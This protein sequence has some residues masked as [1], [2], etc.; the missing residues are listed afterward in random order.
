M[1]FERLLT[2]PGLVCKGPLA[3]QKKTADLRTLKTFLKALGEQ[4]SDDFLGKEYCLGANKAA[5]LLA[6]DS[7]SVGT[8]ATAVKVYA[9]QCSLDS[10]D[11]VIDV[12][13]CNDSMVTL[14]G[15]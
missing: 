14:M 5:A 11:A 1:I 13:N 4:T 7:A 9:P 8:V 12:D 10:L 3:Q 15:C 2:A 6:L